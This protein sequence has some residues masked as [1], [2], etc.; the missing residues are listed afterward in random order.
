MKTIK[1]L[2]KQLDKFGDDTWRKRCAIDTGYTY[3]TVINVINGKHPNIHIMKWMKKE[4]ENTK[5]M[6]I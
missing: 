5:N 4:F 6:F 2:K 3:Q 1:Q